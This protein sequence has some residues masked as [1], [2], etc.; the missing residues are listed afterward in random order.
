LQRIAPD[1][2]DSLREGMEET[3]T[4]HKLNVPA[5]LRPSISSTNV[6]ESAL[7]AARRATRGLT[8]WRYAESQVSLRSIKSRGEISEAARAMRELIAP[9]DQFVGAKQVDSPEKA[10]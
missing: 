10:A 8:R 3:I 6:I 5:L 7:S 4:V 2:A 9:L 1:A